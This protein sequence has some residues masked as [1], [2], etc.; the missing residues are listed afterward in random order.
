MYHDHHFH[1]FGYAGV[2]TGLD[3]FDAPDMETALADIARHAASRE[4]PV[5]GQRLN[6]ETLAEG[7]LPTRHD[8]D[9]AVPDRPVLIYRYCGHI[10]MANSQTLDLASL[11][12]GTVDPPGGSLDRDPDG[13]PNGIL[14]ETATQLAGSAISPLVQPPSDREILEALD[15][16]TRM[17]LGSITGIVAASDSLWCGVGDELEVLCRLAQDL[18]IDV[19]VLVTADTAVELRSAADR[20]R[21]ADGRLTFGG[22]KEW[23]DGSLGG[24][25]AAMYQPYADAPDEVGT[26]RLERRH[27]I[28]MGLVA[29]EIGGA[30]AL[31]AI[32]DRANDMV[33]D[34]HGDLIDLGADPSSLRIEHASILTEPAIEKMAGLGVTAS[35]QPAFLRSEED[36][37]VKRLGDDR[38]ERAYPFRSM[39]EAG[40]P[41][42]GGSDTPVE[43]PDPEIGIRAAVDRYGI[44]PSQTVD[45]DTARSMF[46]PPPS[47][48]E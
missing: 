30:V 34:I 17:G 7:R 13:R 23:S 44:N 15:G 11:D 31:H 39:S 5:I 18:P 32:G 35:I 48:H 19:L 41:L 26:I 25:T 1:P 40:I 42:L 2:V 16:L 45:V 14:R 8:L 27:A 24:H 28:E 20:I 22:W 33:L 36:W 37:L 29:S 10:A 6:D 43:T 4:G 38:M 47:L 12:A 46:A 21:N 9:D 3:L